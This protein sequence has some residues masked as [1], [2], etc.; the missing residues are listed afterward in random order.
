MPSA[1]P[2][3]TPKHSLRKTT[4]TEEPRGTH[5]QGQFMMPLAGMSLGSLKS[6][7]V[8]STSTKQRGPQPTLSVGQVSSSPGKRGE[9][10]RNTEGG[11]IHR[12]VQELEWGARI[13]FKQM[14]MKRWHFFNND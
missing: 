12:T 4:S 9:K 10:P 11:E 2:T 7:F 5:S 3:G 8:P 6:E 14:L 13:V 1:S